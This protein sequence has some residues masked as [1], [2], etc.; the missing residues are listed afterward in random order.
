MTVEMAVRTTLHFNLVVRVWSL[1]VLLVLV[2]D[3]AVQG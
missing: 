3:F 1:L 2:M